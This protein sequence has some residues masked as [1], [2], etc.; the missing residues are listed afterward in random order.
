MKTIIFDFDGTIAD[1]F[2]VVVSIV[3]EMIDRDQPVTPSEILA[4]KHTKLIDV[5][6]K[7][8]VPVWKLP[9][10]LVRGRLIM[11]RRINEIKPFKGI[12]LT[13]K[14]LYDDGYR[15][16][17][18]SSNSTSNITKFLKTNNLNQYFLKVYAGVGLFG[19]S[20]VLKKIL[21]TN[22]LAVNECIYIGDESRDIQATA[23]VG[24]QCISVN[25]GFNSD[26]LLRKHHPLA[27]IS[28]PE[29]LLTVIKTKAI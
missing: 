24:M 17:I 11:S 22:R 10:M 13:I 6:K 1:S 3:H 14:Q 27:V 25:W 28:R 18:M 12:D 23:E 2:A 16:F 4:L 21:K 19:K 26:E 7:E 8:H 5:A 9:F 29:E 15:L 20:R